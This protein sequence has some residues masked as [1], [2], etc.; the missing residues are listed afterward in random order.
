MRTRQT[1]GGG[2]GRQ[3]RRTIAVFV[4][5]GHGVVQLAVRQS[6]PHHCYQFTHLCTERAQAEIR[7]ISLLWIHAP[8][9][10]RACRSHPAQ[11]AAACEGATGVCVCV[12]RVWRTVSTASNA[13]RTR[14]TSVAIATP[15]RHSRGRAG[16]S[17]GPG[18]SPPWTECRAPRRGACTYAKLRGF[19]R[20]R[21]RDGG[22][23]GD[24]LSRQHVSRHVTHEASG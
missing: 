6:F 21:P 24:Q 11:Q 19:Y 15:Q 7:E 18:G 5:L 16:A 3:E 23:A 10:V 20:R 9:P 8:R 17:P 4:E 22:S 2:R 14:L 12:L 1:G 13:C